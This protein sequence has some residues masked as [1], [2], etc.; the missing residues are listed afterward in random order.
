[1]PLDL[2]I[3]CHTVP[4]GDA[5][6]VLNIAGTLPSLANL[7]LLAAESSD[8]AF[9]ATETHETIDGPEALLAK[10]R[11]V[12]GDHQAFRCSGSERTRVTHITAFPSKESDT[13]MRG[14]SS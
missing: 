12:L 13:Q 4:R 8:L 1:M 10:V 3:L 5:F 2:L 7:M 11:H 14:T 6:D 9:L